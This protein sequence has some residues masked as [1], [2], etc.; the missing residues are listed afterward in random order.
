MSL[1]RL[2]SETIAVNMQL[3]K[4]S[5]TAAVKQWQVQ[6]APAYWWMSVGGQPNTNCFAATKS[7]TRCGRPGKTP[8]RSKV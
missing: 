3:E 5:V 6:P 2:A 8:W 1:F 7:T 4:P